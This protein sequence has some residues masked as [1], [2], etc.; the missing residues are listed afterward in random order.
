M[1]LDPNNAL[2]CNKFVM[3]LNYGLALPSNFYK[4]SAVDKDHVYTT[5]TTVITPDKELRTI[6]IEM[7]SDVGLKGGYEDDVLLALLT[8]AK[9]QEGRNYQG[10]KGVRRVYYTYVQ[11][12]RMLNYKEEMSEATLRRLVKNSIGRVK[13]AI[14]TLRKQ[15]VRCTSFM[16]RNEDGEFYYDSPDGFRP[17]IFT[18][19]LIS[20]R[21]VDGFEDSKVIHWAEFD[22]RI[23]E[24]L[25]KEYMCLLDQSDY[26]RLKVGPQ[27]QV[28]RFLCA[29]RQV[30]GNEFSFA[31]SELARMMNLEKSGRRRDV[32]KKHLDGVMDIVKGVDVHIKKR[33]DCN[34]WDILVMFNSVDWL[35]LPELVIDPTY[36]LFK[37]YY[38]SELL[39]ELDFL[40][41]DHVQLRNEVTNKFYKKNKESGSSFS[42]DQDELMR[43]ITY[44]GEIINICDY[45]VDIALFQHNYQN[46]PI[47]SMRGFVMHLLDKELEGNLLLPEGYRSYVS[48]RLYVKE[49]ADC[50]RRFREQAERNEREKIEKEEELNEM[51][52]KHW[53]EIAEVEKQYVEELREKARELVLN[54]CEDGTLPLLFEQTVETRARLLAK[55]EFVTGSFA[56]KAKKMAKRKQIEF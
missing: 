10:P 27:R 1:E 15:D 34:D 56:K 6:Q 25:S 3:E 23:F 28:Y 12:A 14:E 54:E 18:G 37:K 32:I 51:F 20:G 11:I 8:L 41:A 49:K 53:Q 9:E 45:L 26:L 40:E 47:K 21:T 2:L 22:D 31:L 44:K 52:N 24:N 50:E 48:E 43:S 5:S 13:K 46:Y 29:K 39:N 38:G 19:D 33:N 7:K 4:S 17:L 42:G 36:S 16:Y 55:A 30:F 35:S